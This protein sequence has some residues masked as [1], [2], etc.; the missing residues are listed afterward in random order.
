M[1]KVGDEESINCET[2]LKMKK[3]DIEVAADRVVCDALMNVRGIRNTFRENKLIECSSK[4]VTCT[5]LGSEFFKLHSCILR[6]YQREKMRDAERHMCFGGA[7][8]C[9]TVTPS[10]VHFVWLDFYFGRK[11]GMCVI[12]V[13]AANCSVYYAVALWVCILWGSGH[14]CNFQWCRLQLLVLSS[15]PSAHLELDGAVEEIQ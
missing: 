14:T 2:D 6:P 5:T 3:K 12:E 10:H 4:T 11:K 15:H 7:V 8:F 1:W 13:G 9:N